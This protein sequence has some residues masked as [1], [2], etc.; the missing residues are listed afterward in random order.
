MSPEEIKARIAALKARIDDLNDEE[1]NELE[2]LNKQA[3]KLALKAES[4]KNQKELEAQAKEQ[5]ELEVSQ[6]VT[7]AVKAERAKWEAET[8]RPADGYTDA[9]WVAKYGDERKFE[10]LD[11]RDLSFA[12]DLA[13][14]FKRSGCDIQLSPA[15]YKS[16]SRR[17]AEFKGANNEAGRQ[18]EEYVKGEFE[19]ATKGRIKATPES[20]EAAIK[21]ATDPM[22]T[23]GSGI[24][25]D[26]VGS[27]YSSDMWENVRSNVSILSRI[28]QTVIPDGYSNST[29]P[30]EGADFTVYKVAETTAANATTGIPNASVTASQIGTANKNITVAKLGARG[31]HS[32]ELDEDSLIRVA[33]EMR[34]KAELSLSERLESALID[35]DTETSA[36]KNINDIAGT[37]AA[38]DYFLVWDGFRKLALVTNT[39]NSRSANGGLVVEDYKDTL[40]LLGT[41]GL[42]GADPR[43]VAFIQDFNTMWAAMELPELKTRD[44]FNPAVLEGGRITSIYRVPVIDSFFMHMASA[45]AGYERKVNT[46]GK[47]D[48][49][50][51][52]NNT[53]GS[54][55]AVR[56]DQWKFAYKRRMTIE[57]TRFAESD[58]WQIVALMRAGLGYR[59]NEASAI[60]YN[61][62]V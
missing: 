32:G 39:G 37:P 54:I 41:A 31:M 7:A 57:T 18:Q 11:P 62:G 15:A 24:G 51:A 13:G 2:N 59:D 23:G 20:V 60:T 45:S 55:L 27:L 28:P 50:T 12:L 36:N 19:Y 6:A 5:R 53:T 58:S 29:I 48:L 38:T 16:M 3:R 34:R 61:V 52:S 8:R 43:A 49:D 21:A 10:R 40:R 47:V 56:F 33:P 14:A 4:E 46:A 26:W 35:G 9:P 25:S 30:L 17:I 22:Y 42:A 44:T 1:L